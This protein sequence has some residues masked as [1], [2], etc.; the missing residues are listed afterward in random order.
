MMKSFFLKIIFTLLFG[1]STICSLFSQEIPQKEVKKSIF[2]IKKNEQIHF[3]KQKL[4]TPSR[5]V[6]YEAILPGLG[7]V[8]NKKAWHIP[9]VYAAFGTSVFFAIDNSKKYRKYRDAYADF[10]VY[11][12][13]LKQPPQYPLPIKE[14]KSQRFRE[15]RDYDFKQYKTPQLES[16]KKALKRNKDYFRKYRDLSYISIAAVYA[17]NLVWVTTDA[18][19][20]Y[21]DI[22]DDLSLQV[23]PQM[24]TTQNYQQGFGMNLIFTFKKKYSL[25][26]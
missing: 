11:M 15:V 19:F 10:S 26:L 23:L 20:F 8:Y 5:A 21:Y 24:F 14:P 1:S 7:H 17:L 16:F 4:H 2:T 12:N 13:Y 3:E 22:S 18:H 9:I 6:L 25:I